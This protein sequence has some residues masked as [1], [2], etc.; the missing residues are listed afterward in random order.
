MNELGQQLTFFVT[1]NFI[2]ED[3]HWGSL[4]WDEVAQFL[5]EGHQIESH[6]ANHPDLTTVDAEEAWQEIVA[7]RQAIADRLGSQVRFFAYPGGMGADDP[8]LRDMVR[9][10]GYQAAVGARPQRQA[11]TADSDIWALPRLA[12]SQEYDLDLDPDRP[13]HF[14]MRQVDPDFPLPKITIDGWRSKGETAADGACYEAGEAV[15][16]EIGITN[17]GEP[18]TLQVILSLDQDDDHDQ[19]YFRQATEAHLAQ[20]ESAIFA[21]DLVLGED[22]GYGYLRQTIQVMDQYGLLGY[23]RSDW[24]PG[25]IMPETCHT[26]SLPLV[27][28]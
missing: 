3:G 12:I 24:S 27:Q 6:S 18:T 2:T 22:L 4:T 19:L 9:N 7:S 1:T 25:L 8:A 16:I 5:D 20:N 10:A 21:Y 17:A 14:F 11:N 28:R 26:L 23:A 13:A 15:T